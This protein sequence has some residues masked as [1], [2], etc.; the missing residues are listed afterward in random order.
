MLDRMLNWSGIEHD[1][2]SFRG[3]DQSVLAAWLNQL[4]AH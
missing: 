2:H 4:L 3:A 1:G